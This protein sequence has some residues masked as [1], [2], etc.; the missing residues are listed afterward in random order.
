MNRS[1]ISRKPQM[2]WMALL[3]AAFVTG[4]GGGGGGGAGTGNSVV[5]GA[6]GTPGASATN[7][8]VGSASPGDGA[9]N[10]PTSTNSG[11]VVTGTLLSA[12]FSEPMNPAT[13][14]SPALTFTLT[15]TTSGNNVPGTVTMNGANTTATF[16][17][18][19][20]L[21]PN[22]GYTATITT[23]ARNA[24]GTP[25]PN[26]VSW[27]FTTSVVATT[28]R[29]PVNLGAAGS[30][31]VLTK[32]GITDVPNSAITGDVGASP[33]TGAAILVTCA[34]V[35][36]TIYSVDAAGP[37]PC[38][39]TNGTLLTTAIG[40]MEIAY[41]DA[42]GRTL[43]DFTELQAGN[44]GGL[45]LVPGLYKWSSSVLIPTNVT[46]SGGPNDVWIF[47]I[48]GDLTQAAATSVILAGGAVPK[49]VFWQTFGAAAIGTTA[50]FEG[51]LMSQ[52]SIVL[53]T[54]ASVNG[55][56]LA[57]TAVSL[58]QNAVTQPAP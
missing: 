35:T 22:T 9:T 24:G 46:L 43:P 55:R 45:T 25:M 38:R 57:Q 52:T 26:P 50:H 1:G 48:A 51:I 34:E 16:T 10:V 8:T 18:A 19:A 11:S 44:I 58:D 6:A 33:I 39:V 53:G 56:L 4:C 2:W 40:D 42:A 3:L 21:T 37:L 32:T 29:A 28:G 14:I 30:F 20:A 7:P 5:P 17:P 47:Q 54:G 49:N 13:I 12:T 36:G 15:E 23:A 31:A 27:S 41:T